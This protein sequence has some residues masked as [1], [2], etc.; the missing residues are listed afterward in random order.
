MNT[1]LK[2]LPTG[3][4]YENRKEA[5]IKLGHSNYNKALKRGD[6]FF[7]STYNLSDIII[8]VSQALTA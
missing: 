8:Q 6:I 3:E 5:K 2:Y 4:V 1:K 7:L